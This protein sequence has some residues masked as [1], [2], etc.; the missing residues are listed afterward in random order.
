MRL[1]A[2]DCKCSVSLSRSAVGWSVIVAFPG[3][4]HLLFEGCINIFLITHGSHKGDYYI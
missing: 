1:L 4:T 3:H 2:C